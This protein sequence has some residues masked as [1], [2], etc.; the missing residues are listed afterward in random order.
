MAATLDTIEGKLNNLEQSL[1]DISSNTGGFVNAL[2]NLSANNTGAKARTEDNQVTYRSF[3]NGMDNVIK[4]LNEIIGSVNNV[5]KNSANGSTTNNGS[6]Y[7]HIIGNIAGYLNVAAGN[8][9]EIKKGI[10]EIVNK[11]SSLSVGNNGTQ[12][13]QNGN[14]ANGD[15]GIYDVVKSIDDKISQILLTAAEISGFLKDEKIKTGD[16]K[17]DDELEELYKEKKKWEAEDI[18]LKKAIRDDDKKTY[19]E[20]KK[21]R[22][23][24]DRRKK[25][26]EERDKKRKRREKNPHP[27]ANAI[28]KTISTATA[29]ISKDS[30]VSGLVDKGI[31]AI[32]SIGPWSSV[33][34][35]L[36]SG[37]KALF[38][39]GAAHDK[40]STDYARIIGGYRQGKSNVGEAAGAI[41]DNGSLLYRRGYNTQQIYSALTE[42]A[43][44]L[45]RT[46][47]RLSETSLVSA[48]ELKRFGIDSKAISDFDTFGKSIERTDAFFSRLYNEVSKKGLSFKNVSK[49]VTDNLKAAQKYT[50]AEG[51]NG[52]EKMAEKSVQLKFNMQQVFSFADKMSN[53]EQNMQTSANLNALGGMFAMNADPMRMLYESL[54]DVTSLEERIERMFG[55]FGHFDISK[56]EY[57]MNGY[58]KSYIKEGAKAMGIDENEAIQMAMMKGK[59]KYIEN[60]I[61]PGVSSE[62]ADYIKNIAEVKENGQAYVTIDGKE[63]AVSELSDTDRHQLQKEYEKRES[64]KNKKLGD[65]YENTKS[66]TERLDNILNYLKEKLGRWVYRI[67]SWLSSDYAEEARGEGTAELQE[68]RERLFNSYGGDDKKRFS[69]E[70]SN[71]S[72]E[73]VHERM[74]AKGL[75]YAE[76]TPPKFNNIGGNSYGFKSD[77]VTL[78][79]PSHLKGGIPATYGGKPIELEGN[80][81]VLPANAINKELYPAL[82]NGTFNPFSYANELVR[83]NDAKYFKAMSVKP[84]QGNSAMSSIPQNSRISLNGNIGMPDTITI[85]MENGKELDSIE[86]EHVSRIVAAKIR[87]LMYDWRDTG[88][89][90][91][92]SWYKGN[93]SVE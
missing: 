49:A 2:N 62:V 24:E 33:A 90:K 42:A 46:T 19:D 65:I 40:A 22:E 93:L 7:S 5:A 56:G 36:L 82:K 48:M 67:M 54:N 9:S 75:K 34:G 6:N 68:A 71:M 21:K 91:E 26:D 63:K 61:R 52:L 3:K 79:G 23:E 18:K 70:V 13:V 47:E 72:I 92:D 73:E 53:L 25:W 80:E 28:S 29:V 38:E 17:L 88:Y 8:S 1:T 12:N 39:L 41:I 27:V 60:Q 66:V 4:K 86:T 14:T 55:N 10:D 15:K 84:N 59:Y 57:T 30:S 85:K 44:A 43:E 45:G 31:G 50:F 11:L 51:L 83:N 64:E 35:G 58:E 81:A 78:D 20:I 16:K 89:N 77:G 74:D 76:G 32:S 87:K 37:I 69:R